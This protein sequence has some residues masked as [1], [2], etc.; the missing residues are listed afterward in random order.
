M[1]ETHLA[2]LLRAGLPVPPRAA[3]DPP[4]KAIRHRARRRRGVAVCTAAVVTLA[5]TAMT[6]QLV[7]SAPQSIPPAQ[8]LTPT[9][10]ERS[11]QVIAA[12]QASGA[13]AAWRTGLVALPSQELTRVPTASAS[14]YVDGDQS[15]LAQKAKAALSDGHYRLAGT[16]PSIQPGQ[17]EIDFPDGGKLT[18]PVVSA[19]QA[20]AAVD[21]GDG[22][23]ANRGCTL[24]I[25]DAV[26]GTAV[27]RTSRGQIDVPAWQFTVTELTVPV[28]R[29]A[30]APSAITML[31]APSLPPAEGMTAV[32]SVTLTGQDLTLHYLAGCNVTET[33]AIHETGAEVVVAVIAT[34]KPPGDNGVC[35][36]IG[37]PATITVHLDAPLGNRVLL[38]AALS[39]PVPVQTGP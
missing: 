32:D 37:R 30:V 25:T 33:G 10:Q 26:L 5:V 8:Q 39:G 38:D 36:A 19:A 7:R 11:Q 28:I 4:M 27:L 21:R 1:N 17:Y 6:A 12:W 14:I 22:P 9:F 23:C 20:Y 3:M 18:V 31:P 13:D 16:L 24:T 35:L 34:P 2:E 29:I 15:D